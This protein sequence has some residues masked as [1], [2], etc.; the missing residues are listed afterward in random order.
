MRRRARSLIAVNKL[1]GCGGPPSPLLPLSPSLSLGHI[2]AIIMRLCSVS[3]SV[4]YLVLLGLV[5]YC[6]M[7]PT[8]LHAA[9]CACTV[10][11]FVFSQFGCKSSPA[12]LQSAAASFCSL[13]SSYFRVIIFYS[14]IKRVCAAQTTS[15]ARLRASPRPRQRERERTRNRCVKCARCVCGEFLTGFR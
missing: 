8:L 1:D 5:S 2:L 6:C 7:C 4:F 15:M 9:R 13:M 3:I 14:V 12:S 10:T 11:F